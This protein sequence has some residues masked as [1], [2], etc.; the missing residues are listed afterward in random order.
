[1]L[2]RSFCQDRLGTNIWKTQ[3]KRRVFSQSVAVAHV[4]GGRGAAA[5]RAVRAVGLH[6]DRQHGQLHGA[7][8]AP[9][10]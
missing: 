5:A 6:G 8:C 4:L 7:A 10:G 9:G 1:M 3:N 2:H